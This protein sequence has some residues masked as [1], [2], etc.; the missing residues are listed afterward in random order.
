MVSAC[1]CVSVCLHGKFF[2]IVECKI[3]DGFGILNNSSQTATTNESSIIFDVHSKPLCHI[4]SCCSI[5]FYSVYFFWCVSLSIFRTCIY[6][7]LCFCS[8]LIFS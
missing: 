2:E 1:V 3:F 4:C 7:L 8:M 6:F 5:G